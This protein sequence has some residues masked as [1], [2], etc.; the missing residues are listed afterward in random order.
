MN[1]FEL[2]KEVIFSMAQDEEYYGMVHDNPSTGDRCRWTSC[3]KV[4]EETKYPVYWEEDE[5]PRKLLT[6][7]GCSCNCGL[8][9]NK[10]LV[11]NYGLFELLTRLQKA[12]DK[13]S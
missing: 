11:Y 3:E 8:F 13:I 4:K 5:T 2:A 7:E 9:A 10:T 1:M 6:L 12:Q